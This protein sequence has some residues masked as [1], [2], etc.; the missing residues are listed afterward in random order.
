[1]KK[2]RK[3]KVLL[4]T[5]VAFF[6]CTRVDAQYFSGV[7]DRHGKTVIPCKYPHFYNVGTEYFYAEH[8]NEESPYRRSFEGEIF[9]ANGKSV[10]VKTPA[11]STLCGLFADFSSRDKQKAGLHQG[12][13]VL[14][15]HTQEGFGLCDVDGEV[16]LEPKYPFIDFKDGLFQV[17][18]SYPQFPWTKTLFRFD[19]VRRLRIE[20]KEK[21][22]AWDDPLPMSK[23]QEEQP[24]FGFKVTSKIQNNLPVGELWDEDGRLVDSSAGGSYQAI[25]TNL[26]IK[27]IRCFHF[28]PNIWRNP[29]T[30]HSPLLDRDIQFAYFLQDYDLIGMPRKRVESLLGEPDDKICKNRLSYYLNGGG[31]GWSANGVF[32]DFR[33]GKVRR[34]QQTNRSLNPKKTWIYTNQVFSPEWQIMQNPSHFPLVPKRSVE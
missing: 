9:D 5:L 1:L 19:A 17:F 31:C 20:L 21:E 26:I 24:T 28:A 30:D 32:V 34:W 11:G 10:F 12:S 33:G 2:W 3:L 25:S 4:F 14:L 8:I 23:K 13:T 7:I 16:L 15:I 29:R 22:R 6:V 27:C 18:A